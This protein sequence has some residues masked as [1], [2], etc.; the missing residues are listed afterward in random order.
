MRQLK[1]IEDFKELNPIIGKDLDGE[2]KTVTFTIEDFKNVIVAIEADIIFD[3]NEGKRTISGEAIG[4]I[5][6]YMEGK[7][8]IQDVIDSLEVLKKDSESA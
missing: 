8:E 2:D 1:K 5:F 7:A 4:K 3:L 6:E